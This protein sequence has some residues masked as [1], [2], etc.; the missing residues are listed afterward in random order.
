MKTVQLE[1]EEYDTFRE[2]MRKNWLN[3]HSINA[4]LNCQLVR[5]KT[6]NEKKSWID[7]K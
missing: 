5:A 4:E 2:K 6:Q 3:M 7:C 1:E